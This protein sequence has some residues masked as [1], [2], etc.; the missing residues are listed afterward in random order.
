MDLELEPTVDLDT[1]LAM[2]TLPLCG[3]T[4]ASVRLKLNLKLIPSGATMAPMDLELELTA[5]S[6]TM[7][8]MVTLPLCGVTM[9]S[10]R[11]KLS[12]RL[13]PTGATMAPMEL[14]TVLVIPTHTTTTLASVRPKPSP[15][16]IP[17]GA[18][19]APMELELEPTTEWEWDTMAVLLVTLTW[20]TLLDTS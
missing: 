12:L 5:D 6:D 18:T 16:L 3:V 2:A 1:M 11:L 17:I 8:A 10:V 14:V 13:I 9:A 15:R 19:M 20:A 7:L 4:M